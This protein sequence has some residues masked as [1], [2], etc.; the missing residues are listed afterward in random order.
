MVPLRVPLLVLLPAE[1]ID[2]RLGQ[3][4]QQPAA[5]AAA[6]LYVHLEFS[7]GGPDGGVASQRT[8]RPR[9]PRSTDVVQVKQSSCL[10]GGIPPGASSGPGSKFGLQ[11]ALAPALPANLLPHDLAYALLQGSTN[12]LLAEPGALCA[13]LLGQGDA[14]AVAVTGGV[15]VIPF[16]QQLGGRQLPL[17]FAFRASASRAPHW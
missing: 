2:Q 13:G 4:P 11:R 5:F 17:P 16:E 14:L 3:R 12:C 6:V 8:S 15:L 1:H 9:G 7:V 10:V